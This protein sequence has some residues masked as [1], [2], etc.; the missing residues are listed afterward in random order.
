MLQFQAAAIECVAS[1]YRSCAQSAA[2]VQSYAGWRPRRGSGGA[3]R[4][5]WLQCWPART[6]PG[7]GH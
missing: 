7:D 1:Q 4:A 6:R 2:V 3:V 5:Q